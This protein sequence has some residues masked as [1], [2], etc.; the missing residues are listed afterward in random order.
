MITRTHLFFKCIRTPKILFDVGKTYVLVVFV[1][2]PTLRENG[3]LSNE[4]IHLKV[5]KIR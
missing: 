5:S 3:L 2:A 4:I 1:I